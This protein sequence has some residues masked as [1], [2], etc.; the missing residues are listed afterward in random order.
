MAIKY[1]SVTGAT[2]MLSTELNSLA[3][4]SGVVVGAGSVV[5][6]SAITGTSGSTLVGGTV[7]GTVSTSTGGRL[8]AGSRPNRSCQ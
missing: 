8:E 6:T 5:V 1:L 4:G 7:S 2:Q 3:S